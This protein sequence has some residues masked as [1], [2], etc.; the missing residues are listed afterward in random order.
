M[1]N[2]IRK[3][4]LLLVLAGLP[5]FT[6]ALERVELVPNETV[7][8]IRFANISAFKQG[9]EKSAFCRLWKDAQVREFLGC[10]P[11]ATI[12]DLVMKSQND[13]VREL[14]V[15][16]INM[17][18][19]EVVL[20]LDVDK[21]SALVI[22]TM[23]EEDFKK[24]QLIDEKITKAKGQTISII[25]STFQGVEIIQQVQEGE[26]PTFQTWVNGSFLI[27]DNKE[28]VER[29][30]MQLK[31][32]PAK[33]PASEPTFE[34]T[35]SI[36][37]MLKKDTTLSSETDKK[38]FKALGFGGIQDLSLKLEAKE[39][40]MVLNVQLD[41][42]DL[43]KGI[44]TLIDPQP[45]PLPKVPFIPKNLYSFNVERINIPGFWKELPNIL[46]EV[47]PAVLTQF[48]MG[49]QMVRQSTGIDIEQDFINHIGTH[50]LSFAAPSSKTIGGLIAIELKN[51]AAFKK[52]IETLVALPSLQAGI[53]HSIEIET[54]L[55][56]TV[57]SAKG[58]PPDQTISIAILDNYLFYGLS[59]Q[60]HDAI[61]TSNM[62]KGTSSYEESE[63]IQSLTS[64]IPKNA[65]G[66]SQID[67]K[68]YLS[69]VMNAAKDPIL[70]SVLE[71][72]L[73]ELDSSSIHPEISKLPPGEHL[74][75]FFT[76]IFKFTE[77]TPTGLHLKAVLTY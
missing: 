8:Q 15:E 51:E 27:S 12:W 49:L 20:G 36:G 67:L 72:L 26:K 70:N 76:S 73:L 69:M 29:A 74:S 13:A 66:Y 54:F 25:K 32:E 75:T 71:N 6:N 35:V 19:G 41:V 62:A 47:D 55:E 48:N 63:L 52:S 4:I 24:S 37:K 68:K 77:I 21:K 17:I 31:K 7:V 40:E 5:L 53:A 56:H 61:R 9:I 58:S 60:V 57:Y 39:T 22:T 1:K 11:K 2:K 45:L 34:I 64:K 46:N 16:E 43:K 30:I 14:M 28:W 50:I 44:F 59:A 65:I 33:E 3:R 10:A 38:I 18:S 23:T 42:S